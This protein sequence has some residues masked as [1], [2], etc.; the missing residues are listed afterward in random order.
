[1]LL[2]S[3]SHCIY[4]QTQSGWTWMMHGRRWNMKR[5]RKQV[6]VISGVFCV[7]IF[8]VLLVLVLL[9]FGIL[10]FSL[11]YFTL[12]FLLFLW[13]TNIDKLALLTQPTNQLSYLYFLYQL[14]N[15]IDSTSV[16]THFQVVVF[17]HR[18]QISRDSNPRPSAWQARILKCLNFLKSFCN[19]IYIQKLGLYDQNISDPWNHC[20]NCSIC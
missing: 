5:G 17:Y 7:S 14:F 12:L 9:C 13:H 10:D 20:S 4:L 16:K 19:A 2:R 15:I 6:G 18:S 11:H 1:M 8:T 3:Q